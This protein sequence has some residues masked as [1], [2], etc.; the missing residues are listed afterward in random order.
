MLLIYKVVGRQIW[1]GSTVRSLVFKDREGLEIG[2]NFKVLE[3]WKYLWFEIGAKLARA[4][5]ETDEEQELKHILYKPAQSTARERLYEFAESFDHHKNLR[6][7]YLW[8]L[9]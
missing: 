9:I 6:G 8:W 1:Q 3:K 2:S 7:Y 4:K 5:R